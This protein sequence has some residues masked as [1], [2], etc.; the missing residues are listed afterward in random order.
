MFLWLK[1]LAE[2]FVEVLWSLIYSQYTVG[3]FLIFIE[4]KN[5][6]TLE[7]KKLCEIRQVLKDEY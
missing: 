5:N 3:E 2:N 4:K 7:S 6:S 1:K